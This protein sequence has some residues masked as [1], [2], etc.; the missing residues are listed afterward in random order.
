MR[1]LGLPGSIS[2]LAND[3]SV[4]VTEIIQVTNADVDNMAYFAGSVGQK[5]EVR[6]CDVDYSV[7]YKDVFE[8]NKSNPTEIKSIKRTNKEFYLGLYDITTNTYPA[9]AFS[10]AYY[11]V[12]GNGSI[13]TE[14]FATNDIIIFEGNKWN[15]GKYNQHLN[16]ITV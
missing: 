9:D 7:L 2:F 13:G 4:P 11:Y 5:K 10:G 6:Y 8:Y 3:S 14:S 15:K 12:V 1:K 16:K